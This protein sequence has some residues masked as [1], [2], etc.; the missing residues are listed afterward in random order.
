MKSKNNGNE[1]IRVVSLEF[2]FI[3][4]NTANTMRLLKK[5]SVNVIV[6]R[7]AQN[8]TERKCEREVKIKLTTVQF[9]YP[10]SLF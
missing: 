6:N 4:G 8:I 7:V 10:M 3:H 2:H 9:D 5:R 1:K